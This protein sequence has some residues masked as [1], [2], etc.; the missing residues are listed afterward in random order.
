[1][2]QHI[3]INHIYSIR[4]KLIYAMIL[5]HYKQAKIEKKSLNEMRAKQMF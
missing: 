4:Y 2:M 5:I 3:V 1:M